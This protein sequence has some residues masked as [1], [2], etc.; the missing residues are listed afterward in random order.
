MFYRQKEKH[1]NKGAHSV[2][3]FLPRQHIHIDSGMLG[4]NFFFKLWKF[5]CKRLSECISSVSLL[6][7]LKQNLVK[8]PEFL[9]KLHVGKDQCTCREQ[10]TCLETAQREATLGRFNDALDGH[11]QLC[12]FQSLSF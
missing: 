3:V 7:T 10:G 5:R 6:L 4:R 2:S 9:F 11:T 8:I 12:I 1:L